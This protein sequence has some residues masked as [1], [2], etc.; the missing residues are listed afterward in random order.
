MAEVTSDQLK[1]VLE[2][3]HGE[4]RLIQSVPIA[5][6]PGEHAGWNG[7]VYIFDLVGHPKAP[8]AYAWSTPTKDSRKPLFFSV[9]HVGSVSDPIAAVRA[10]LVADR[11][12]PISYIYLRRGH[13]HILEWKSSNGNSRG[14]INQRSV[15]IDIG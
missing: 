12:K 9:L 2:S 6:M 8:R 4:A 10:A 3:Q 5:E 11:R 13:R 15:S 7:V 14:C 1:Q